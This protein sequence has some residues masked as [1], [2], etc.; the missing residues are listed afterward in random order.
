MTKDLKAMQ[1]SDRVNLYIVSSFLDIYS[2]VKA[3]DVGGKAR[4]RAV[5]VILIRLLM[6][7][8]LWNRHIGFVSSDY[9]CH[10]NLIQDKRY[11]GQL[12]CSNY[13]SAA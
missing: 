1:V 2:L 3:K 5:E 11:T 8:M 7:D 9:E 12:H 6:G 10:R 4:I 13:L